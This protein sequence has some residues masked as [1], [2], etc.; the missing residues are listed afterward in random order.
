MFSIKPSV[1]FDLSHLLLIQLTF[2]C[3]SQIYFQQLPEK[4]LGLVAF[5]SAFIYRWGE[6]YG[7]LI[8]MVDA[9][10]FLF[11]LAGLFLSTPKSSSRPARIADKIGDVGSNSEIYPDV[12]E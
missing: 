3:I 11:F 10:V 5:T 4:L 2:S 9:C 12:Y 6:Q 8:T 1:L 7:I